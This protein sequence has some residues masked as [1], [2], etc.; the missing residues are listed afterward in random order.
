MKTTENKA[1]DGAGGNRNGNGWGETKQNGWVNM[2]IGYSDKS[3]F[4]RR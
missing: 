1:Q 4:M 3:F 2:E